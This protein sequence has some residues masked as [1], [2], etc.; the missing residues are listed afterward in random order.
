VIG[1]QLVRSP[2]RRI[3]WQFAIDYRALYGHDR[4]GDLKKVKTTFIRNREK[5]KMWMISIN[6]AGEMGALVIVVSQGD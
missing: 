3:P 1:K 2:A 6:P 4:R 5:K